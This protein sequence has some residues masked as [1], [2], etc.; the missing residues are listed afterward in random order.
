M[1]LM[2]IVQLLYDF[3][4]FLNTGGTKKRNKEKRVRGKK[5]VDSQV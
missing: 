3:F 2:E 1:K 4:L 5:Q